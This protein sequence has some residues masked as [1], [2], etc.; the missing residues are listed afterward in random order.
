MKGLR[1]RKGSQSLIS[2]KV[3]IANVRKTRQLVEGD[4]KIFGGVIVER[5][6][7]PRGKK[8]TKV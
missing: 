3:C 5:E 4:L 1:Y 8:R 2:G 7:A 6:K